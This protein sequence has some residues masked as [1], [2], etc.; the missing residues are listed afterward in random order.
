MITTVEHGRV[1]ELR[2][3]RPPVNALN[4]ALMAAL[5]AA[6][7][8][9]ATDGCGG[10]VLSGTPGRFSGGL[11]V[12]ELLR[13][14]R[15]DIRATWELFFAL[16]RDI[17]CSDFPTV[18][19]LTGHSPAGGTVLAVCADYRV[20]A[21]GPYLLGLNEVQVGL[22]VPPVLFRVLSH[23]VGARQAERL[24]VGGLLLPPAE[25]LRVGLVDEVLPLDAVVPRA[26]AWATEL[27][28][29]PPV[30]MVTTRRL[31]RRELREAFEAVTPDLLDGIVEQ[32][33]SA[34]TQAVM[35]ALAAKLGK[36]T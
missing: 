26:V 32:W 19:A 20:L 24:A 17:A 9:A 6:L 36:R 2:L 13:L 10:V 7:A 16:L 14:G 3:S 33:F 21:E 1:R 28:G 18:A 29:R 27:A 34:E 22:S 15:D 25:A 31:A 23:V 11:D 5:R 12:P 30:A 35:Q 4:P 8:R